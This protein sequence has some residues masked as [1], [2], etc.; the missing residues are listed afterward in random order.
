MDIKENNMDKVYSVVRVSSVS[1]SDNTSL[2][3]QKNVIRSYCELY[4]LELT[5]IIEEVYTGQLKIEMD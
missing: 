3:N 5:E 1:Q 4:N 2:T